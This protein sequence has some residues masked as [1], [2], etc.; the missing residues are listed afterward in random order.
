M[1]ETVLN[2]GW[3]IVFMLIGGIVGLILVLISSWVVPRV[4]E[5]L[6][7]EHRRT[8]GDPPREHGRGRVFRP[9]RRRRDSRRE[10]RRRGRGGGRH[11]RRPALTQGGE[12]NS[13]EIRQGRIK[14]LSLN[15]LPLCKRGLAGI[16]QG[17]PKIIP[18]FPLF[19]RGMDS[20]VAYL[21]VSF[22]TEYCRH[23]GL[24]AF[25]VLVPP[26]PGREEAAGAWPRERRCSP[27]KARCRLKG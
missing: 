13:M 1:S 2:I 7:P 5:R 17:M 18:L 25:V 4:I 24:V 6:H 21:R 15:N 10:P 3:A 26:S 27:R 20:G 11:H 16:S 9:D 22:K 14:G 23:L 12:F 19:Q 8:E